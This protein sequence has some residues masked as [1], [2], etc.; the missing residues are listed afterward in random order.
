MV[1]EQPS[2]RDLVQTNLPAST[3]STVTAVVAAQVPL[4]PG[5]KEEEKSGTPRWSLSNI[6]MNFKD[7]KSQNIYEENELEKYSKKKSLK[8]KKKR[9]KGASGS[10]SINKVL[11]ADGKK[12][13]PLS[14]SV[15]NE[16]VGDEDDVIKDAQQIL[17]ECEEGQLSELNA[18]R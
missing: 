9:V 16:V 15:I 14:I 10:A 13:A 17:M 12:I 3:T 2:N 18:Q 1:Q 8:K 11:I 5:G 4:F 7:R 6:H